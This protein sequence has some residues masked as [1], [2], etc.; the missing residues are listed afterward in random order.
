MPLQDMHQPY[1]KLSHA[2]TRDVSSKS[3]GQV[4]KVQGGLYVPNTSIL[5]PS[6]MFRPS[7]G[8]SIAAQIGD[9]TLLQIDGIIGFLALLERYCSVFFRCN[10]KLQSTWDRIVFI[11]GRSHLQLGLYKYCLRCSYDSQPKCMGL[12][13]CPLPAASLP[14]HPVPWFALLMLAVSLPRLPTSQTPCPS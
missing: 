1:L 4:M 13:P 2:S 9:K 5:L 12:K 3:V 10:Q 6:R 8:Q 14:S 11:Y 7:T